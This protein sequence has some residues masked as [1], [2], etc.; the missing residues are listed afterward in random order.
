MIKTVRS[1][2]VRSSANQRLIPLTDRYSE[3]ITGYYAK[4]AGRKIE[5]EIKNNKTL[6]IGVPSKDQFK[7][8]ESIKSLSEEI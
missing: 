8:W 7:I 3:E 6:M 4:S 5:I 2:R 1:V